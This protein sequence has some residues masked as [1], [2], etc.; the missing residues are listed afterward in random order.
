MSYVIFER[1]QPQRSVLL[2]SA[3]SHC[4]QGLLSEWPLRVKQLTTASTL[5]V[6]GNLSQMSHTWN[7]SPHTLFK[8]PRKTP[9]LNLPVAQAQV[10]LRMDV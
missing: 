10:P 4:E 8:C 6:T 1:M 7:S 2:S 5:L 9:S 3:N